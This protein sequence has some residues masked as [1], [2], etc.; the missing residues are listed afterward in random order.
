M[1]GVSTRRPSLKKRRDN[2]PNRKEKSSQLTAEGEALSSSEKK[3]GIYSIK[4]KAT[5]VELRL[6]K[7]EEGD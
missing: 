3:K 1:K 5:R 4:A 6:I 7:R 2:P